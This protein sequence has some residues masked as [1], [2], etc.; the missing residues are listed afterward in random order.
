MA[1]LGRQFEDLLGETELDSAKMVL[2]L[3]AELHEKD[4]ELAS[5]RSRSFEEIQRNNKTREEEFEKLIREQDNRIKKRESE[6]ARMLA[7][8]ESGLWQKYQLMITESVNRQ[9][10]ES[11]AERAL[12]ITDIKKKEADLAAQKKNLRLETETLFKTWE[13]D[14]E[15]DFKIERETFEDKLRLAR[16]LAQKEAAERIRQ[17]EDLGREKLNQQETDFKN[18]ALLAAEGIRSQMRRE[19][20]EELKTLNDRLSAEFAAREQEQYAHYTDWLEENKKTI[21]EK[22]ARQAGILEREYRE[23][24]ARTEDALTKARQELAAREGAWEEKHNELKKLYSEKEAALET[25]ARQLQEQHLAQERSLTQRREA[26]ANEAKADTLRHQD[27]LQKKEKEMAAELGARMADFEA[28]AARRSKALN[29]RDARS[30]AERAE[31]ADLRARIGSLLAEKEAELEQTYEE[32]QSLIRQSLEESLKIKETNLAK[33]EEDLVRQHTALAEQ[34][35]AALARVN[36]LLA[37]NS[38]LKD[39]MVSRDSEA[40]AILDAERYTIDQ[41]RQR[42]EEDFREKSEKLKAELNEREQ[43]LRADYEDKFK[44]SQERLAAQLKI[45]EAA[46]EDERKS[47][48]SHAAELEAGFLEALKKREAEVTDNFRRNAEI[49]R[50]QSEAARQ[51]WKQEKTAMN[52]QAEQEAQRISAAALEAAA[53]REE[54]LKTFYENREKDARARAEQAVAAAQKHLT[55]TFEIREHDLRGLV[56][57]LEEK[58]AKIDDDGT[59]ARREE[60][61]MKEELER[62]SRALEQSAGEKQSLIQENLTKARDLRQ[63]LERE[64]LEKLKAIEQNYLSQLSEIAKRSDSTAKTE[65]EDYF[66]KLQF[67]NDDFNA[68]LAAQAKSLEATFMERERKL[69]ASM[70]ESFKLKGQALVARQEQL[71]SSYQAMLSEKTSQID[72]DRALAENV[73]R[74]KDELEAKKRQLGET[75]ASYDTRIDEME[76]KLRTDH[77]A[78]K[79]DLEDGHRIRTSQLEAERAKLRG[80]LE[81]EQRLVADLQK[82]EAALQDSYAAREA[83]LARRFK[84]ARE[85]LEKDYQDRAQ[86]LGKKP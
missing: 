85:R 5:M 56:R 18:R 43:A 55:E 38:R 79:K 64:F 67:M 81:Q 32:R 47:L 29:E 77:E 44:N 6:L 78:R 19:R 1:G 69:A 34:K 14:R 72:M 51:A 74:T 84:E 58:L 45:R 63:T 21:E 83:E 53:R 12:L 30:T 9:R 39:A 52:A 15:A 80:L 73:A 48:S 82:R 26:L 8:K 11:E 42:L 46:L 86:D 35:D 33:K 62:L 57:D 27:I 13:K 75:I 65:R 68:R 3:T 28:E 54:E 70:E 4:Q 20:V 59:V 76:N 49:M 2:R 7:E 61:A 16:D 23:R 50:A 40:R 41:E 37:E 22:A 17:I 31:L 71:E 66:N 25:A 36:A 10:T 60:S 24:V